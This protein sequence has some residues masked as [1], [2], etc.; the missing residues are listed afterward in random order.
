MS[1][2]LTHPVVLEVH[3][4]ESFSTIPMLQLKGCQVFFLFSFHFKSIFIC[5]HKPIAYLHSGST[6]P[7]HYNEAQQYDG[8]IFNQPL[9]KV[10]H[11]NN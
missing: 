8:N 10:D 4:S 7:Y 5:E 11:F 2:V 3:I 1:H 6:G 9:E